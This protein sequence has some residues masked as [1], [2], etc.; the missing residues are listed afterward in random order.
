MSDKL[1]NPVRQQPDYNE[2]E[3][4]VEKRKEEEAEHVARKFLEE[5]RAGV[6]RES[7]ILLDTYNDC[8]IEYGYPHRLHD[9]EFHAKVATRVNKEIT[10]VFHRAIAGNK[11]CLATKLATAFHE[12]V[13]QGRVPRCASYTRVQA[14]AFISGALGLS[15]VAHRGLLEEMAVAHNVLFDDTGVIECQVPKV[16]LIK[17]NCT[18]TSRYPAGDHGGPA[19]GQ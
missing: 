14:E 6:I 3:F 16:E 1:E 8:L 11:D 5:A 4:D 15:K 18:T 17:E 10:R 2:Q 19:T 9:R 7:P 13:I 12:A